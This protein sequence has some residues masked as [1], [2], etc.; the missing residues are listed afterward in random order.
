MGEHV[1]RQPLER[2]VISASIAFVNTLLNTIYFYNFY[3]LPE[4]PIEDEDK[5]PDDDPI[6]EEESQEPI[7]EVQEPIE[8]EEFQVQD[9][10]PSSYDN[11]GISGWNSDILL[12]DGEMEEVA[13][14]EHEM[15][16]EGDGLQEKPELQYRCVFIFLAFSSLIDFIPIL[17]QL[18]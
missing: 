10:D 12:Q 15:N 1:G 3:R 16:V 13:L 8:E 7:E 17:A 4:A 9:Q 2:C 14:E 18:F 5:D 6:G 11:G